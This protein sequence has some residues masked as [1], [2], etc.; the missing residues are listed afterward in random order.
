MTTRDMLHEMIWQPG[1]HTRSL[2]DI[3]KE[4]GVT[5]E[6]VR[7]ILQDIGFKKQPAPRPATKRLAWLR[8]MSDSVLVSMGKQAGCSATLAKRWGIWPATLSDELQRRG[9][10]VRD[11][12]PPT[13]DWLKEHDHDGWRRRNTERCQSWRNRN[14]DHV[15][16]YHR[17][18]RARD[19]EAYDVYSRRW[20]AKNH[21]YCLVKS[22]HRYYLICGTL[23]CPVCGKSH[24]RDEV[25]YQRNTVA[26]REHYWRQKE[27]AEG[28]R[29]TPNI[30]GAGTSPETGQA[31]AVKAGKIG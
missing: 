27:V 20:Q 18:V 12:R 10:S 17:A 21:D 14:R 25:R 26:R 31:T 24:A 7:Q 22:R 13:F 4:L 8:A 11:L 28:H 15:N 16:A 9:I 2:E 5:R 3:G 29:Q 19:P 6:R 30:A 23:E 1:F